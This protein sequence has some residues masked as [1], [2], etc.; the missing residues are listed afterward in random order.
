VRRHDQLEARPPG[1]DQVLTG[2]RM[3]E[4]AR[5]EGRL[6]VVRRNLAVKAKAGGAA[7]APAQRCLAP[8][9]P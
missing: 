1:R 2:S 8:R 3:P 6:V 5:P 4:P 7:A 9:E